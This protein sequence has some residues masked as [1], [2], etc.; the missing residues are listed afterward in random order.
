MAISTFPGLEGVIGEIAGQLEL[1]KKE[2]I[3]LGL[4][5]PQ[6]FDVYVYFSS[7]DNYDAAAWPCY[8]ERPLIGVYLL[9]NVLP[10]FG[11][12]ESE[13]LKEVQKYYNVVYSL[14]GNVDEKKIYTLFDKGREEI[15]AWEHRF[16]GKNTFRIF[17]NRYQQE[18]GRSYDDDK[19]YLIESAPS[20]QET[21]LPLLSS[22]VT[23]SSRMSAAKIRHE[24]DHLDFFHSKLWE[25]YT[26]QESLLAT[27]A[28]LYK[29]DPQTVKESYANING[30]FLRSQSYLRPLLEG[31]A[32][33]FE[34]IEPEA[35][36]CADFFAA[37]QYVKKRLHGYIHSVF[38]QYILKHLIISAEIERPVSDDTKQY[39]YHQLYTKK[40]CRRAR[41]HTFEEKNV[42]KKLVQQILGKRMR[43]WKQ[44]F[45]DTTQSTV[46]A[47]QTAY[48]QDASR[49]LIANE[50]RNYTEF[51]HRCYGL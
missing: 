29:D 43:Q 15:E 14:F 1:A 34:F 28:K 6:D 12:S 40:K 36:Y 19:Q 47:L 33:F 50:A 4:T 11:K 10:H 35:W 23:L 2:R 7:P 27:L 42:D 3:E 5:V 8:N 46:P 31:R 13:A 26:N 48:D 20:V 45:L 17:K 44:I 21:F 39:M 51:L 9:N 41:F 37:G 18:H 24:L 49:F 22:M 25:R 38:P 32:M 30:T 16:Q